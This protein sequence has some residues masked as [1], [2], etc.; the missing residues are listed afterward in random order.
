ILI[1]IILYGVNH[2]YPSTTL[3]F[4]IFKHV[5]LNLGIFYVIIVILVFTGSSNAVNLTDGLDGLAIGSSTIAFAALGVISYL[6][7]NAIFSRYLNLPFLPLAGELT[8]VCFSCFGAGL[9]FLWYNTYPAEVFMGDVGSLTLGALFGGIAIMIKQE[10][11]IMVIGGIFVFEALSV[12]MQVSSY[13]MTKKRIFRMT[14]IHHHFELQ[15]IPEPKIIMR[16]WI[17]AFILS[18]IAIATLKLR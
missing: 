13:K 5:Q 1:F 18:L 12:I 16:F 7:G 17:V 10:I 3:F 14:P 8:V 11:L 2:S 9:G 4:P 15:G 6:T